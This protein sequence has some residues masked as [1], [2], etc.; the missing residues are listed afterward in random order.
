[1]AFAHQIALCQLNRTNNLFSRRITCRESNLAR[2]L[3]LDHDKDDHFVS[4]GTL[5]F[6]EVN[7]VKEIQ[8]G[9]PPAC[10]L[11]QRAVKRVAFENQQFAANHL[12][13]RPVVAFNFDALDIGPLPLRNRII[14]IEGSAGRIAVNFRLNLGKHKALPA[15][16][17]CQV[18]NG[19]IHARCVITVANT[20]FDH[21][22]QLFRIK[23]RISN[24]NCD[25]R[26]CVVNPL[27]N[28]N[29]DLKVATIRRELGFRG[30]QLKIGKSVLQVIAAQKLLVIFQAIRVIRVVPLEEI[31][32]AVFSGIHHG[33]Q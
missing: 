6:L 7:L 9:K 16:F 31:P 5:L 22:C 20:G 32:P 21:L 8:G 12:V 17:K 28:D 30:N 23:V 18:L 25:I 15:G 1:M 11:N 19:P 33:T 4:S 24:I 29:I 27:F 13:Q 3:F 10:A 26:D 14:D 2:G